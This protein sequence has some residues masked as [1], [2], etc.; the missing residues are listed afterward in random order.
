MLKFI[1]PDQQSFT[2]D[3]Y[4]LYIFYYTRDNSRVRIYF[5]CQTYHYMRLGTSIQT[6][7]DKENE[8]Q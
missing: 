5:R 3:I 6:L 2:K 1:S 8:M 7:Y 4:M